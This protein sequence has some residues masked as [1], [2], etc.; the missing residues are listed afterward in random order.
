MDCKKILYAIDSLGYGGAEKQLV[1]AA[2]G[3]LGRGFQ[4]AILNLNQD[5]S[6]GSSRAVNKDI[7]LFVAF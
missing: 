5:R 7:Q 4:V 2:E 1:F 3:M 6:S